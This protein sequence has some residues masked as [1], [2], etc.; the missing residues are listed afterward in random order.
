ME[1]QFYYLD[2]EGCC[3]EYSCL[4]GPADFRCVL[5]E[6]EDCTW[7]RDGGEAWDRLNELTY[8]LKKYR[9]EH[10]VDKDSIRAKELAP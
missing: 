8:L 5:G 6:P 1:E 2:E 10:G 7:Y 3:E 4:A 9:P